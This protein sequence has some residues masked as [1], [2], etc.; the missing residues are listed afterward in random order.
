MTILH[1]PGDE[2]GF[3]LC[4]G[5]ACRKLEYSNR[6]ASDLLPDMSASK[7]RPPNTSAAAF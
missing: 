5:L 3:R 2:S 4:G 6:R 1:H 7:L